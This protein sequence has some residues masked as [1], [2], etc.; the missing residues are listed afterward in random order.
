M[1]EVSFNLSALIC[2]FL[3]IQIEIFYSVCYNNVI[4]LSKTLRISKT[5]NPQNF[6]HIPKSNST[7]F[8]ILLT[9]IIFSKGSSSLFN[10]IVFF[11]IFFLYCVN[12]V[13]DKIFSQTLSNNSIYFI[14]P[15]FCIFF[16]FIYSVKSFLSLF[17][18]IE[19]YSVLYYF[20]FLTSYN[21]TNQT[22]L[23]YKNGLLFLL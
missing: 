15:T 22:I 10:F 12:N 6:L 2:F 3:V 9:C 8:F 1:A 4:F 20:C 18:F 16:Y 14:L 7:I 5:L 19:I 23:K 17:F 11:S 21:F 13:I